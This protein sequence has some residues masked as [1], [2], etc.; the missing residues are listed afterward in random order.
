[1]FTFCK[2]H[3]YGLY[4]VLLFIR[5]VQQAII[6]ILIY[7]P[8][9][10]CSYFMQVDPGQL[11]AKSESWFHWVLWHPW[12]MQLSQMVLSNPVCMGQW[13]RCTKLKSMSVVISLSQ[14]KCHRCTKLKAYECC[15]IPKPV[16]TGGAVKSPL[17]AWSS[18][19]TWLH[20][21]GLVPHHNL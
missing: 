20:V 21:Y 16:V 8:G 14:F 7:R 18:G 3:S 10:Q 6:I 1:M 9:L 19:Q 15:D 12:A 17:H 5:I 11:Y 4:N 2:L 13:P